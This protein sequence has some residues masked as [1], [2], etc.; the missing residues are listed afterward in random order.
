MLT[1]RE[2][3]DK[4]EMLKYIHVLNDLYPSLTLEQYSKELDVMLPHNYGQVGVFE[5]DECLGISGFW[6]GNKLWCGK[7]L[8]LASLFPR[9]LAVVNV[10]GGLDLHGVLLW[11]P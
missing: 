8:E 6:I 2:L 11:G 3:V 9:P 1:I 5:A 4:D 10:D 7:Y